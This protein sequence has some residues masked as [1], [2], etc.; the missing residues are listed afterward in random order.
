MGAGDYIYD[1]LNRS[2][3]TENRTFIKQIGK[4]DAAIHYL[5]CII[6]KVVLT[7]LMQFYHSFTIAIVHRTYCKII[8]SMTFS[9]SSLGYKMPSDGYPNIRLLH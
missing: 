8:Q 3:V 9:R 5:F 1:V 7:E 4:T 2:S 6:T